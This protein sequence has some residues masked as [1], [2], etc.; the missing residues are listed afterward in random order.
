MEITIRSLETSS[1]TQLLKKETTRKDYAD[2]VQ[3]NEQA[4]TSTTS[5]R[6]FSNQPCTAQQNNVSLANSYDEVRM[7]SSMECVPIGYDPQQ[8]L[9]YV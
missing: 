4:R 5:I 1:H 9:T 7:A 8:A 2:V 6:S 3:T